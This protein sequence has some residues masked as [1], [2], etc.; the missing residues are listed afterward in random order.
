MPAIRICPLPKTYPPGPIAHIRQI[1]SCLGPREHGFRNSARWIGSG[2]PVSEPF[3][4]VPRQIPK[5]FFLLLF[6]LRPDNSMHLRHAVHVIGQHIFLRGDRH[7]LF[8]LRRLA[9][10]VVIQAHIQMRIKHPNRER[11]IF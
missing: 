9:G 11:A 2:F 6:L 7:L 5:P 8:R 4:S 3:V 1:N 10:G